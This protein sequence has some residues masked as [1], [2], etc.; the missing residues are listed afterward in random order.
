MKTR[1]LLCAVLICAMTLCAWGENKTRDIEIVPCPQSLTVLKGSV[2]FAGATV[3]CDA[4]LGPKAA[5]AVQKFGARLAE[6]SGKAKGG[7]VIRFGKDSNLAAENYSIEIKGSSVKILANDYN[8]VVYAIATLKQLLPV[9]IYGTEPAPQEDWRVA[10]CSIKDGPRFAYRGVHMDPCRHFWSIE[11]TKRYID[12]MAT[13]KMNRLHWHLTEDQGWRI[14]IKALPKLQEVSAWRNGT[15]IG[16][17]WSLD[18]GIRYGGYYTQEQIKEVIAYAEERGIVII[19][20]IDLPGHMVAALAAYP[21]LACF[22]DHFEVRQTWGISSSVLCPGKE[23]TFKFLETVLGEVAD[24]FPSEYIHIGGDECPK[25]KWEVCPDCQA[26]I[27]ELGLEDDEHYTAEQ[28]LQSYVTSRM[29]DFL[30]TKGKKI[31]GWDEILEGNLAPGATVMSW[32]GTRGGIEAAQKGFDVIMTPSKYMYLDYLQ[33]KNKDEEPVGIGGYLP[34]ELLYSYD[35]YDGMT[36]GTETHVLG[37]QCNLWT[38]YVAT[39]EHL[40]YMLLPRMLGVSEIGWSKPS[41]K[42]Y[43][44]FLEN[45]RNHQYKVLDQMGYNYKRY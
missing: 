3:R 7:I 12:V 34:L 28:K 40:E 36:P 35:P 42:N 2:N 10:C 13:Y 14:E 9:Q 44:R 11:E 20:E 30:A 6:A 18:D 41:D 32:R 31:I 26:R 24:L 16:R 17:E 27:K 8:G 1:M 43:E 19:P 4:A 21:E 29:Q 5:A 23:T 39:P 38:E 15:M 25:Y 22:G 33:S 45:V 37:A